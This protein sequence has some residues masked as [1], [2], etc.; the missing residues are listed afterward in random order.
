MPKTSYRNKIKICKSHEIYQNLSVIDK[1]RTLRL[2]DDDIPPAR[3][4]VTP[5]RITSE[6]DPY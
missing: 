3:P 2:T 1:G 4:P 6:S 5:P